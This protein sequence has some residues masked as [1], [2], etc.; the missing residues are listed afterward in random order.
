MTAPD[1][2]PASDAAEHAGLA[3]LYARWSPLVY[4]FALRCVGDVTRAEEVTGRV[5]AR[6]WASRGTADPLRRRSG[7]WV[8]LVRD[9][10]AGTRTWSGG[11]EAPASRT[12]LDNSPLRE[13]KTHM[14][15]ERLV[16]ADGL[17]HLDTSSRRVL[18]MAL[19]RDLTLG[20]VAERTGLRVEEVRSRA[21]RSL[22]ELRE[23]L[24]AQA[25]AH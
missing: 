3:D 2:H 14:L 9:D 10:I 17:S 4:G 15:A 1:D 13:S 19:D 5:F 6:A 12:D 25:D 7:W 24:E 16:V 22:L 20:D 18:Q 21:A 23:R 11:P 8:G